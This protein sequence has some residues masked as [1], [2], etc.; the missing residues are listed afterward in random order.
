M[1]G[2][3]TPVLVGVGTTMQREDDVRRSREAIDLMVDAVRKTA[4]AHAAPELLASVQRIA[5]PRGRWSYRNPAGM[6]ATA[7]GAAGATTVLSNVGVLQQTLITDTCNQIA[8]GAIDVGLVVGGDAGYRI[9]R[10]QLAGEPVS[11]RESLDEPDVEFKP[12]SELRHPAELRAGLRMPVGL[13]AI[14]ASAWRAGRGLGV[15]AH[16]DAMARMYARFTE[17]AADNPHAWG[18]ERH[19]PSLIRDASDRNPMHAFPY[20]RMHSS[21]WS[22]DQACAL[23]FCSQARAEALGI[24]PEHWIHP[25]ASTESNHM[26]PVSARAELGACPGAGITA[27][28]A[29][30][31]GGLTPEQVDLVDFYSCFPFAVEVYAQE[32]GFSTERDLSL[33]GGMAFAGGPYNNYA[34]QATCRMAELMS[35]G[36][37]QT[38]LVSSVSGIVTK[39]AFG[40]WSRA[41]GPDAYV[42]IDLSQT[43][44]AHTGTRE[45]LEVFDGPG[46]VA[47]HTVLFDKTA[48]PKGVVVA[49]IEHGR[50]TVAVTHDL[51]LV[52][53]MQ[54]EEFCGVPVRIHADGHFETSM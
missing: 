41:P 51:G 18:R 16:R 42:G 9:R 20:A 5:V 32:S 2:A 52:A 46:T 23:L 3:Q 15:D 31:A 30:S 50:R 12:G 36:A 8:S 10:A 45:V 19:P 13:Y 38:G 11:E 34:L 33:T 25:L 17:I 49:D 21:N 26:V 47:G 4:R 37:G 44:A 14:C 6:I 40:L 24:G 22:V 27:R 43:V 7:I 28:A 39:Q 35:A 54:A 29:L 1:R 48:P 53:T